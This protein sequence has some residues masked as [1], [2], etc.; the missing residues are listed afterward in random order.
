MNYYG[1][2]YRKEDW[3]RDETMKDEDVD[4][5]RLTIGESGVGCRLARLGRGIKWGDAQ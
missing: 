3:P 4:R 5:V 2:S 1:R